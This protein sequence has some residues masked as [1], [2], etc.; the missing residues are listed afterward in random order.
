MKMLGSD[1][2]N[3]K[4]EY[5]QVIRELR[6]ACENFP[7]A[8]VTSIAKKHDPFAVLIST[9]LSLRTRDEKTTQAFNSLWKVAD[10]PQKIALLPLTRIQDL[11]KPVGFYKNKPQ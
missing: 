10:S 11:I 2:K 3:M 1:G 4:Q 5:G 9:V 8:S 6:K 7:D